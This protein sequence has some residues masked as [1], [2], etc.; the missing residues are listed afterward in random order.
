MTRKFLGMDL[1]REDWITAFAALG[2]LF[3]WYLLLTVFE[4]GGIGIWVF[5]GGLTVLS[6]WYSYTYFKKNR[7]RRA[8]KFRFV[9][10]S[11]PNY[12]ALGIYGYALL[13]GIDVTA[14]YHLLPL[15]I[16]MALFIVN[17]TIIYMFSRPKKTREQPV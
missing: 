15:W 16:I 6:V 2:L 5:Y 10:S 7:D 4:Q 8:Y 3:S 13:A 14:G 9:F 11:L 17:I 1:E 12:V